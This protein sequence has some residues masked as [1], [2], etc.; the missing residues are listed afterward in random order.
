MSEAVTVHH[1]DCLEVMRAMPD[2]SVDLVLTSPPYEAARTY[3]ISFKLR[4]DA[5]VRWA[6]ERYME[7]VRVSRGAV[8]GREKK[9]EQEREKA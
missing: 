4:G 3:G 9:K 6:V 5:W 8:R 2:N 1:G 7:C